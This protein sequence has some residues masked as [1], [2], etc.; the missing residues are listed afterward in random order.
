MTSSN[1]HPDA[2]ITWKKL[3]P[4]ILA[5]SLVGFV[6]IYSAV[7]LIVGNEK[8]ALPELK[9]YCCE[10]CE[11]GTECVRAAVDDPNANKGEV[12]ANPSAHG[13]TTPAKDLTI[14]VPVQPMNTWSN[15]AY[16]V[17]GMLPFVLRIRESN[18]AAIFMA[19][20]IQLAF[21]SAL[22]HAYGIQLTQM[23]D[24]FGMYLVFGFLAASSVIMAF[25]KRNWTML[26]G[27]GVTAAFVA[28]QLYIRYL[29]SGNLAL[30]VVGL[31]ILIPMFLTPKAKEQRNHIFAAIGIFV[32]A[33]AFR[34]LDSHGMCGTFGEHSIIQG[35]AI[36][37]VV[38]AF[39]IGYVFWLQQDV[40]GHIIDEAE[41]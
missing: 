31:I 4:F 2:S 14:S 35:H 38:S 28:L 15:V 1:N 36:W 33:F 7:T 9:G 12:C 17:V 40:F 34:I 6:F 11:N 27:F 22:F 16:F 21:G 3:V 39:G 24:V 32:I 20:S 10:Y 26:L 18:G 13:S 5:A 8:L 25:L 23:M 37:H 29:G 41:A 30:G 19:L